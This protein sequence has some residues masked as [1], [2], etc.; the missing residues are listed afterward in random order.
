MDETG[1]IQSVFLLQYKRLDNGQFQWMRTEN[2]ARLL[3]PQQTHW[4]PEGLKIKQ[5]KA[6]RA[7][8]PGA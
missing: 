6:I 5:P 7:G 4:L 1:R 2:E 8:K 3:T